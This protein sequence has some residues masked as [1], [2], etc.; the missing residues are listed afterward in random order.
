MSTY[1]S[2]NPLHYYTFTE[3]KHLYAAAIGKAFPCLGTK[4]QYPQGKMKINHDVDF[5][6]QAGGLLKTI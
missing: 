5:H 2:K 6:P 1:G 3:T 4:I